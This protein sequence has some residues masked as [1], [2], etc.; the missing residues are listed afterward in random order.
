MWM[1]EWSERAGWVSESVHALGA[2]LLS[3]Q[4]AHDLLSTLYAFRRYAPHS[5]RF[6]FIL[7][8]R[9]T[10]YTHSTPFF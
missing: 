8:I 7:G 1:G 4:V 5:F 6:L 3:T 10:Q 9:P 2:L